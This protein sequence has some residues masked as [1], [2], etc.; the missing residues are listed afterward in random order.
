M[1]HWWRA[2]DEAVDDPKLILLS[3]KAHRAWF[4][5]MCVASANAGVLP[6]VKIVAVKLR[7]PPQRI[8]ALLAELVLARLFDQLPNGTFAPHNWAKRQ[9][10]TDHADNTNAERQRRHRE[11]SRGELNQ[12]KALR[13]KNFT[14]LR[15][16]VTHVTAK[17]P[18]T[19]TDIITTTGSEERGLGKLS[20]SPEG[21]AGL[22]RRGNA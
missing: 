5:L 3:D 2:H 11:K 22:T 18:D 16:G 20:L 7:M 17:R 10:K 8:A 15:N 12:L 9:Y 19:E 4:N 1:S 13:D 21:L 14:A 6:D